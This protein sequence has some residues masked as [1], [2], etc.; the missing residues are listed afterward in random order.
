MSKKN[1][2]LVVSFVL[3]ALGQASA[4]IVFFAQTLPSRLSVDE[5]PTT[6]LNASAGIGAFVDTAL[7]VTLIILLRQRRNEYKHMIS[8]VDRATM[9]VEFSLFTGAW[10]YIVGTGLITGPWSIIALVTSITMPRNAV[11]VLMLDMLPKSTAIHPSF[12]GES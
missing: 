5:L 7:A 8:V 11:Y 10:G 6:G 2:L 9:S 3:L 12:L 4:S 1:K